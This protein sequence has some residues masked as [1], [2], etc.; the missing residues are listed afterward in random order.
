MATETGILDIDLADVALTSDAMQY[1]ARRRLVEPLKEVVCLVRSCFKVAGKT[2]VR[3]E[4]DPDDGDFY[5]V[6]DC[7]VTGTVKENVAAHRRFSG[8]FAKSIP[9]SSDRRQIRL[10]YLID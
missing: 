4:Q 6:I 10:S 7:H 5:L 3:L 8:L 1:V 9:D 2:S